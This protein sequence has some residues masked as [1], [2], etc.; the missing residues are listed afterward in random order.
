MQTNEIALTL[1]RQIAKSER[2]RAILLVGIVITLLI[3]GAFNY[4]LYPRFFQTI[5]KHVNFLWFLLL[6]GII[7]LRAV[8]S[9]VV[10][11]RRLKE[12][13]TYIKPLRYLN[14][15]FELSIPSLVIL[16]F[17]LSSRDMLAF[18]TPAVYLYFIFIIL[19]VLELDFYISFYSGLFAALQYFGMAYYFYHRFGIEQ[20]FILNSPGYFL[21]V[22]VMIILSS[23]AAG[24]IAIQI[25]KNILRSI[26]SFYE[27]NRVQKIFGQQVSDKILNELLETSYQVRSL[28]RQVAVMFLDIRGYTSFC[29]N[30]QPDE[31]IDFQNRVFSFMIE[32]INQHDGIIN[33]FVGDGF[34]ATFGAPI[35][36]VNDCQNAVNSAVEILKELQ[37]KNET[38]ELPGTRIGIGIH[39]GDVVTG[40]VGTETRKQYSITGNT[41]ILA[42]RIEQLNK[43]YNSSLLISMEVLEKTDLA[44]KNIQ[45]IGPVMVKGRSEPIE[46]YRLM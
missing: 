6:A 28:H 33:Q 42:S 10:L 3:I 27:R 36:S 2:F 4:F 30:K 26:E 22:A 1:N 25:K 16:I 40:N 20:E 38:K 32:I 24:Q 12:G 9:Y 44:E 18:M 46:I 14:S 34:M 29:E 45:Q 35:S 13:K 37:Q 7:I 23:F 11:G 31:I 5:F 43:K 39:Y 8:I 41:V 21:A 17:T 15:A 19:S